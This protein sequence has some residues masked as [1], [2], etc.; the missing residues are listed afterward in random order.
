MTT[1]PIFHF[2]IDAEILDRLAC[3]A[4]LEDLR[5]EERRL[6][7][8]GCGRSFPIV[9]GIPVLVAELAELPLT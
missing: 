2:N 7:C 5:V 3:P 6:V 8:K 9:D 4:C 1:E